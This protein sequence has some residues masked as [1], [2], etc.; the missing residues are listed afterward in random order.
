MNTLQ[1]HEVYKSHTDND[2]VVDLEFAERLYNAWLRDYG[3]TSHIGNSLDL[4]SEKISKLYYSGMQMMTQ[5]LTKFMSSYDFYALY[6]GIWLLVQS[7]VGAA[8]IH[9]DLVFQDILKLLQAHT[10]TFSVAFLVITSL[11]GGIHVH[12][13]STKRL[14]NILVFV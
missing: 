7:L 12:L 14:G 9:A 1:I 11:T 6:I 4:R 2:S 13:C 3:N 5:K 10:C 8:C